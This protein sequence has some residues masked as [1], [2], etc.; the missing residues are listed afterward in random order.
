MYITSSRLTHEEMDMLQTNETDICISIRVPAHNHW[1]KG[2]ESGNLDRFVQKAIEQ[3]NQMYPNEKN[4]LE[5]KLLDLYKSLKLEQFPLGLGLYVS[6]GI[7]YVV[8]FPFPID[9]KIVISDHFDLRDLL[10]KINYSNSYYVLLID[11]K[12]A[13]LYTGQFNV[14]HKIQDSNFPLIYTDDF[15]YQVPSRSS[16]YSSR[17]NISSFEKD[18]S[19]LKK[20]RY[21]SF[22]KHVDE[23]MDMYITKKDAQLIICGVKSATASFLNHSKHDD[24]IAGVIHGNYSHLSES[25]LIEMVLPIL[26]ADQEEKML[27]EISE[28]QEKIGEGLAEVGLFDVWAAVTEGRGNVLLVEKDYETRVYQDKY[29]PL[30]IQVTAPKRLHCIVENPVDKLIEMHLKKNGKMLLVNNGMLKNYKQIALITR[31]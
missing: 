9:E 5:T 11:E 7:Q 25:E 8:Q 19:T 10:F 22:L 17:S 26:K 2:P 12:Q 30:E 28:L 29:F 14:L 23:L 24:K 18:K 16:S 31:Y 20:S 13:S 6:K 27:D 3:L 4:E 21:L 1:I 15:E